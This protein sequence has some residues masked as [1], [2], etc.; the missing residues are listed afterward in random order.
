[1]KPSVTIEYCPKCRWLL[2]AAYMAQEFLST[3]ED[4][5]ESVSLKPG[6]IAGVYRIYVDGQLLFDRKKYG[7]FPE[8]KQLK[9][10]L[11]DQI[12]PDRGLGHIDNT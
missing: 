6:E 3:F 2:R 10:W 8:I 9:Q 12:N 7:G 1:M 4:E 5:L 11:R